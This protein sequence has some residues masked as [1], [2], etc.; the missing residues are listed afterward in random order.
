MWGGQEYGR[1]IQSILAGHNH[2]GS[3][4][5]PSLFITFQTKL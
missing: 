5:G 4:G 3:S 1:L 2:M